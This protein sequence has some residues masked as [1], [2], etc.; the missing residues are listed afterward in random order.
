MMWTHLPWSQEPAKTRAPSTTF[1]L[2]A[3]LYVERFLSF[4]DIQVIS[5]KT[6]FP[7]VSAN[8]LPHPARPFFRTL[9]Q[10]FDCRTRGRA[11]GRARVGVYVVVFALT[12]RA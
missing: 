9:Q 11:R 12:G 3:N 1:N 6:Y 4:V 2:R 7:T 10:L 8:N 5:P